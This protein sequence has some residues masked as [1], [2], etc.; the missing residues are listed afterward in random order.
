MKKLVVL[1]LAGALMSAWPPVA[2]A[3]DVSE[4]FKKI[5]PS[6]VVI[7]AKGREVTG[8]RGIKEFTET[9]SGVLISK[10]GM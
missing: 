10:D 5:N 6:V 8:A 3:Q 9:G 7:R 4:L 1:F 2:D